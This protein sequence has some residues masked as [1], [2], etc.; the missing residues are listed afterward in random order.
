MIIHVCKY[1]EMDS[2]IS[3]LFS[4]S[5]WMMKHRINRRTGPQ[6]TCWKMTVKLLMNMRKTSATGVSLP[7][8][9]SA[10]NMANEQSERGLYDVRNKC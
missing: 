3:L 2:N 7:G 5:D 1:E 4:T 10:N 8:C 9:C 6:A